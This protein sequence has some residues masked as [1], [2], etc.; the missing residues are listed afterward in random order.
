MSD[1]CS[2]TEVTLRGGPQR[3]WRRQRPRPRPV[4]Q[5][6]RRGRVPCQPSRKRRSPC[7]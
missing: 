4:I 1:L 6:L 2:A 5:S 3:C 7:I